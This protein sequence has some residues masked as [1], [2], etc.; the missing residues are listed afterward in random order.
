MI[1][2]IDDNDVVLTGKAEVNATITVKNGTKVIGSGKVDSKG[3]YR[4][5]VSKQKAGSV[6]YVTAK[7][8]AGNESGASKT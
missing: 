2:A 5:T 7:D 1:N 6:L 4:I 8:A 3:T